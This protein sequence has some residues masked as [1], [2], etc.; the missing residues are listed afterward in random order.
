MPS[1]HKLTQSFHTPQ[2]TEIPPSPQDS[3][4][5]Q[6]SVPASS[7]LLCPQATQLTPFFTLDIFTHY[8]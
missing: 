8:N 1:H 7:R 3:A 2:I 4:S 6:T 5:P